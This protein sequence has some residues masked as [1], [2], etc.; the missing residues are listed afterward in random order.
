MNILFHTWDPGLIDDKPN[1]AGGSLWIKYLW[2]ELISEGHSIL[3]AGAGKPIGTMSLEDFNDLGDCIEHTDVVVL[4]WRWLMDKQYKDRNEA[5]DQQARIL[6]LATG[7]HKPVLVH[8]QDHKISSAEVE[9][10]RSMGNVTLAAP[11]IA[12]RPGFRTLHFPNPYPIFRDP[13]KDKVVFLAENQLIYI[14]NNYERWTQFLEFIAKPAESGLRTVVYGNWMEPGPN[15]QSPEEVRAAAPKV[16]FMGR[17]PQNQ[18]LD[19]LTTAD[20][21]VQLAKDSYC[22]TGFITMRWCEAAAAATLS[23]VPQ[24]FKHVPSGFEE[25]VV[26]DGHDLVMK[27][28]KMQQYERVVK[29]QQ[30]WVKENMRVDAWK[31]LLR[32]LVK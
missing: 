6:M 10:L 26:R 18:I 11:E 8:D 19:M 1:S 3:W 32:E 17:L 21:T 23:F 14:G 5:R 30:K 4:F 16:R 20:A 15:R 9:F 12:P 31:S 13:W 2:R 7:L 22:D 24:Q 28:M 27:Y 25:A 29:Q